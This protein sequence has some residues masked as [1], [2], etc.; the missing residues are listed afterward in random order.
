MHVQAGHDLDDGLLFLP[1]LRGHHLH[2]VL[3]EAVDSLLLLLTPDAGDGRQEPTGERDRT[4]YRIQRSP[5]DHRPFVVFRYLRLV[6]KRLVGHRTDPYR[7]TVKLRLLSLSLS[8]AIAALRRS[9]A[10]D[11]ACSSWGWSRSYSC[12]S[13]SRLPCTCSQKVFTSRSALSSSA[14]VMTTDLSPISAWWAGIV[15]RDGDNLRDCASPVKGMVILSRLSFTRRW[16]PK[17]SLT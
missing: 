11:T 2:P 14:T 15:H 4:A 9:A 3:E 12:L 7:R 16:S 6:V 17:P 1:H 5:R 10:W 13:V 8:A